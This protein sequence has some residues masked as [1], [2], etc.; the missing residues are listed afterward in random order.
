M[1]QNNPPTLVPGELVKWVLHGC[2]YR[3]LGG[4]MYEIACN[5]HAHMAG[6]FSIPPTQIDVADDRYFVPVEDEFVRWVR[7]VREQSV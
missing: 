2:V 4:T 1:A 5:V 6:P 3:Y 7:E